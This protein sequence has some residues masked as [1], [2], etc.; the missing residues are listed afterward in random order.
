MCCIPSRIRL[1][2]FFG[3]ILLGACRAPGEETA[4][5]RVYDRYLYQSELNE[6]I[7]VSASSADSSKLAEQYINKWIQENVLLE[8]AEVNLDEEQMDFEE[9]LSQYKNSLII[10]A[11]EQALLQEK[12]DT[13]IPESEIISY[14]EDNAPN[15]RIKQPVFLLRYVRMPVVSDEMEMV[16]ELIRSNKIEDQDELEIFCQSRNLQFYLNDSSWVDAQ[17]IH[18]EV[19]IQ[20][21]LN[22]Y[23][24]PGN[25]FFEV[26]DEVNAYFIFV[27]EVLKPGEQAPLEIAMEEVRTL[28]LNQR[29]KDL[30]RAMRKSI[31]NEALRK[32][33]VEILRP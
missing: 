31:Y 30:L 14:F 8:Q 27:L 5:A 3:I 28:I 1:I 2:W 17:T 6:I 19:P 10:Y 25:G 29:K 9:K 12:L 13:A 33:E 24:D 7:P 4:V 18:R 15:F 11:Y 26:K 20:Q 21:E 16:R 23:R 32:K 22:F